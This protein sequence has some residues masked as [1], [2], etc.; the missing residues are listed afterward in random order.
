M[1]TKRLSRSPPSPQTRARRS[2]PSARS[3]PGRALVLNGSG[4]C[5]RSGSHA[6]SSLQRAPAAP[7]SRAPSGNKALAA[8]SS[9]PPGCPTSRAPGS[10]PTGV[11]PGPWPGACV[12]GP[13]PPSRG[14]P[15]TRQRAA[16]GGGPGQSPGGRCRPRRGGAK[17][18]AGGTLS[19][20]RGGPPGVPRTCAGSARGAAPPRRRTSSCRQTARAA[21]TRRNGAGVWPAHATRQ[22]AQ[23]SRPGAGARAPGRVRPGRPEGTGRAA[24]SPDYA[25]LL[26]GSPPRQR[27]GG[28][29][30]SRAAGPT[31]A[32]PRPG[33]PGST[34]PGPTGNRPQA[35]GLSTGAWQSSPPRSRPAAGRPRAGAA[36]GRA[37]GWP[38]ATRPS[39]AWA[40]WPGPGGPGGGPVPRTGR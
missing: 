32:R 16:T 27:P 30:G 19:A 7:G 3:A 17:P 20:R 6:S 24:R 22:G 38:Q 11:T 2:S 1:S 9:P 5:R 40:L 25:G 29:G 4:R 35:G 14:R 10:P 34:G 33:G 39:R 15:S 12:L 18:S 36:H 8:G 21:R 23:P 13:A 31:R 28:D 37:P 26:W